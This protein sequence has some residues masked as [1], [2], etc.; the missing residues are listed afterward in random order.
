[1]LQRV[2]IV[3]SVKTVS[4]SI[5]VSKVPETHLGSGSL[6]NVVETR[7]V[8]VMSLRMEILIVWNAT[9]RLKEI[10]RTLYQSIKSELRQN[11]TES[12][13]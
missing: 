13:Q 11:Y 6:K 2:D 3:V 9:E 12:R 8:G 7:L 4:T 10:V 1:M 5:K